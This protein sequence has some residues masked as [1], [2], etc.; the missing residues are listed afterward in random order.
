ML[1][2]VYFHFNI[3]WLDYTNIGKRMLGTR[4]ICFKT[5]L[6]ENSLRASCTPQDQWYVFVL[7]FYSLFFYCDWWRASDVLEH[8]AKNKAKIR[9]VIML[10]ATPRHYDIEGF[11]RDSVVVDII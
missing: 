8:V 11:T 3:R 10:S 5:P 7:L 2:F 6:R 9:L 4:F 1:S